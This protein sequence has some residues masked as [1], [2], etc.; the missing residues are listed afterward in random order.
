MSLS[1]DREQNMFYNL[2]NNK[3]SQFT[4]EIILYN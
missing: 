1:L 3:I 4:S 2:Y